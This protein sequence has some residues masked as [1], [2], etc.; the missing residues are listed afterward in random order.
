MNDESR[1]A[2]EEEKRII[3]SQKKTAQATSTNQLSTDRPFV[4]TDRSFVSTDRSNSP[5]VSAASTSTGANADELSFVYVGSQEPKTI[6]QALKDESWVEAI[7]EDS[8]FNFHTGLDTCGICL[9]KACSLMLVIFD[10]PALS[11]SF[12][13][14][15]LYGSRSLNLFRDC[16]DHLGHLAILLS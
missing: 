13:S 16:L 3:A 8:Q 7:A 4:S 15:V 6:S 5:N 9:L 10:L 12:G 14:F 1:Q 2:F 11:L